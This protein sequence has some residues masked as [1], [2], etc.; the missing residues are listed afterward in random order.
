MKCKVCGIEKDSSQ[1]YKGSPRT[2]KEC[3]KARVKE[4]E[5]ELRNNP[6]WVEKEKVRARDKYKRLGYKNKQKEW[7]KNRPWKILVLTRI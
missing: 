2:C 6:E 7:D 3:V 5:K 1:Y 4:R